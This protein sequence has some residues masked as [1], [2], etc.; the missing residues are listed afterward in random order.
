MTEFRMGS[1][2]TVTGDRAG[3]AHQFAPGTVVMLAT[4]Q[5]SDTNQRRM[6]KCYVWTSSLEGARYHG[7]IDWWVNEVD[8]QPIVTQEEIDRAVES[9]KKAQGG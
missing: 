8:L 5:T 6:W 4:W 7:D 2:A 1:L 3:E 9:I